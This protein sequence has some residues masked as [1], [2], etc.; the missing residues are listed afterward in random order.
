LLEHPEK[1]MDLFYWDA[2]SPRVLIYDPIRFVNDVFEHLPPESNSLSHFRSML[3]SKVYSG[4]AI[5]NYG[6]GRTKEARH[7]LREALRLAPGF[8]DKPTDFISQ[9]RAYMQSMPGDLTNDL[10]D[11]MLRN[12]PSEA[13]LSKRSRSRLLAAVS[14]TRAFKAY[15][16]GLH[17]LVPKHVFSAIWKDPTWLKKRSVIAVF[18]KSLLALPPH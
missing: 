17:N 8:L 16:A 9:I 4:L 13:Q 11:V 6:S 12:L 18:I 3:L 2:M 15:S 7:Q 5:R 1:L 14:I 10:L